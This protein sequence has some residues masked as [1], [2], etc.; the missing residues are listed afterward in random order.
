MSIN[1]PKRLSLVE[2]VTKEIELLIQQKHWK[3]GQ[4][5]PPEKDLIE[6]FDVSRNTLR[7]AIRALVHVG[8]L[9]TK[10]GSGTVVTS[11]STFEAVL[12][13]HIAQQSLLQ[14]LE[15]RIALEAEAAYLAA[16]RRTN[17]DIHKMETFIDI[18]QE[19]YDVNDMERFLEADLSLHQVIVEA[20]NNSI[21]IDLYASLNDSLYYSIAQNIIDIDPDKNE[22]EVHHQLFLAIK[23]QEAHE[24]S[25]IVKDYLSTMKEQ[26]IKTTEER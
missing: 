23:K 7:E 18:C 26:M 2:Q 8:L 14:I 17:D 10:Q 1:K 11:A 4:K 25:R 5:I 24:A 3:V 13:E 19:A 22:V 12:S 16:E 9:T 15:V 21:L 20:S 6:Q